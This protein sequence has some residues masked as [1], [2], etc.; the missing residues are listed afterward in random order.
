L[1][2][3]PTPDALATTAYCLLP[4]AYCLRGWAGLVPFI[5]NSSTPTGLGHVS[6]CRLQFCNPYRVGSCIHML[7]TILQPLRGW[8]GLVPIIYNSAIP[9]G[10]GHVSTCRLQFFNP[11]RVGSCI[12]MSSTILQ[13]LQGWVR[14][15]SHPTPDALATTAYCLLPTAYC[16]RGWAGLVPFIYNSATPTGLGWFG[17]NHLQ[18]CNPYRVGLVWCQSSTILQPLQGWVRL[19]SLPTPDALAKHYCLLPAA[20]YLL[21]TAYCLLPTTYCLLPTAYCYY[22]L[23]LPTAYCLLPYAYF[24]YICAK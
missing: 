11:Y 14:L 20:Y 23:L 10:L 16:L 7:S 21:P 18:F 24:D 19:V 17:A 12:H 9:T 2:S 4:T 5:Y 22:L 15:V 1:V 8:A 6:T 13:P 3:H